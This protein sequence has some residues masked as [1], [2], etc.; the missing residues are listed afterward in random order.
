MTE[1]L[2]A[3]PAPICADVAALTPFTANAPRI[4]RD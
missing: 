3:P 4:K 2:H 1:Y